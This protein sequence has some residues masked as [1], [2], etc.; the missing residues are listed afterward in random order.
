MFY[1]PGCF[2]DDLL[3]PPLNGAFSL[4]EVDLGGK[5]G[6]GEGRGGG[7]EGGEGGRGGGE[8]RGREGGERRR[9]GGRELS[10]GGVLRLTAHSPRCHVC[11]QGP[12]H[13]RNMHGYTS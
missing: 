1:V 9:E 8:G 12:A 2:L 10:T 3:V 13:R 4:V 5:G 11:L 6:G 7:G